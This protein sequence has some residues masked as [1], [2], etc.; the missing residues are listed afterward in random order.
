MSNYSE[1]IDNYTENFPKAKVHI[2][3]VAPVSTQQE[4]VN[5]QLEDLA[6]E[7]NV[8]YDFRKTE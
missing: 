6:N 3:G 7:K 1:L 2:S 8:N 4:N 5:S